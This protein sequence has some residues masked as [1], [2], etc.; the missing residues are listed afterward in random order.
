MCPQPTLVPEL[1]R[2]NWRV[3]ETLGILGFALVGFALLRG[4]L[5]LWSANGKAVFPA[6]TLAIIAGALLI[7]VN[8]FFSRVNPLSLLTTPRV[9]VLSLC[10][11]FLSDWLTFKWS[12]FQG[13]SI[14]GELL[15]AGIFSLILIRSRLGSALPWIAAAFPVIV[16]SVFLGEGKGRLLFADDHT[17][18]FYRLALLLDNF[19][20][21]PFFNPLWNAG[22]DA[23]D[24]F[25]TGV[26]NI[27]FLYYPILKLLGPDGSYSLI[28]AS[29]VF[30][31]VPLSTYV[32][33]RLHG[34]PRSDALIAAG[35]SI[36]SS[37]LWYRWCLKYGAMGFVVSTALIPLNLGFTALLLERRELHWWQY[38]AF[39]CSLTLMIFWSLSGL[40]FVP[41]FLWVVLRDRGVL[42]SA[43]NLCFLAV[44]LAVNVP[45]IL[46]FLDSS[47]VLEF[48]NQKAPSL[49]EQYEAAEERAAN[50]SPG[51]P[52]AER[53]GV[54]SA[55]GVKGRAK[56][57]SPAASLKS[58]RNFATN[59]NPLLIFLCVPGILLLRRQTSMTIFI[60]V[61]PWL[62][63]LGA[64][65]A[66]TVPQLELERML[67]IFGLL[68]CVPAAVC[69][70]ELLRDAEHGKWGSMLGAALAFSF[71]LSGGPVA[72][73]IVKNRSLEHFAW[74]DN[75]VNDL[76]RAI[77]QFGGSGRVVFSGFV[78]HELS[79]GH[80]APL[81]FWSTHP[82]VASSP[83]HNRWTY[84][85]LVPAPFMK[86]GDEGI[87]EYLDLMNGTAV[88]AH[89]TYWRRYF[90][91]RPERYALVWSGG[92]FQMFTRK[93]RENGYFLEG[94]GEVLEQTSNLVR[95]RVDSESA[96]IKFNYFPF[97]KSS[98]CSLSAE[99]KFPE[100]ELIKLSNCKPGEEVTIEAVHAI[101]RLL[102]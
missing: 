63:L 13:P 42:R 18:V 29:V 49:A 36:A 60:L 1:E 44:L 97:L 3:Q 50:E 20:F 47:R 80:L 76:L 58:I 77:E 16:F 33:S 71:I 39:L 78:L 66:P 93:T 101:S 35:L 59:A 62:V 90:L 56:S 69:A 4:P 9:G 89:E 102:S 55:A 73:S 61:L 84:T 2:S 22:I 85:N 43:K 21:I 52:E 10:L 91:E 14:R 8:G 95:L 96:T 28:V 57:I 38:A 25:A 74:A 46:I 68:L 17:A 64:V 79:Q 6:G 31:L 40:V 92:R 12:Y 32:G 15:V 75:T 87:E 81:A 67:V 99:Q 94:Q 98:G 7:A 51:L 70:G 54:H 86:R 37:L 41:I 23:R 11:V 27:Y 72:A 100:L 26:L 19:P 53:K 83:F 5:I 30:L 48:L 88:L 24:F 65:F 45:W 82:L 34:L